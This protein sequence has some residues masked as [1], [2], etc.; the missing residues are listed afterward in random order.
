[1]PYFKQ[2]E[3]GR[4]GERGEERGAG[5]QRAFSSISN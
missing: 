4:K 1:M 3:R 5:E 2:T